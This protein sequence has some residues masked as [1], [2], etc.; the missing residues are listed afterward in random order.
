MTTAGQHL[1]TSSAT[2]QL[3]SPAVFSI[4]R[5]CQIAHSSHQ[6]LDPAI[7]REQS[8]SHVGRFDGGLS[9]RQAPINT[10]LSSC[11]HCTGGARPRQ[12]ALAPD[13]RPRPGPRKIDRIVIVRHA[14][15]GRPNRDRDSSRPDG[16]SGSQLAWV[17]TASSLDTE[18]TGGAGGEGNQLILVGSRLETLGSAGRLPRLTTRHF[19]SWMKVIWRVRSL[20]RFRL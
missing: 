2:Q 10:M 15:H 6:L 4:S 9:P 3:I 7:G 5:R 17:G 13:P 8:P 20:S 12:L 16:G 14:S 1:H 11:M 19:S 18:N